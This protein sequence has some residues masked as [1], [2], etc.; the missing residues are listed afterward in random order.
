MRLSIF[1]VRDDFPIFYSVFFLF[2]S[3]LTNPFSGRRVCLR[4][5]E[6][7][8]ILHNPVHQSSHLPTGG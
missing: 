5:L 2:S 4:K 8:F 3:V 6:L 1:C 7:S